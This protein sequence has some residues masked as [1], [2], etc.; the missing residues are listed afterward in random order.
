[1][2]C[3]IARRLAAAA[4][5]AVVVSLAVVAPLRAQSPPLPAPV[6]LIVDLQQILQDAKAAKGV[7]AIINQEYSSYT[8]EVA[9]QED[10]LQ[11]AR[12]ELERQRTILAPDAFNT[13]ARDLQQRYDELGQVVQ[14]R[15]QSLQQSLNEAMVQVKNAALQVIADIVKERK[16]NLVI[17]KQAVVFEADGMDVTADAV[18]RL[19]QKL[20]SVP[21]NLPKADGEGAAKPADR[22]KN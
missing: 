19:D 17:E 21:V 3:L 18:A 9:Q 10:E 2:R 11:K 1:M 12:A 16:A 7:Q 15:R 22:K 6:I 8:K 14:G 20:T 4:T 13:R 5:I